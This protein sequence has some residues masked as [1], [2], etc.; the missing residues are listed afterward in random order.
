MR[1]KIAKLGTE[2]IGLISDLSDGAT[3]RHPEDGARSVTVSNSETS[4]YLRGLNNQVAQIEQLA[5]LKGKVKVLSQHIVDRASNDLGEVRNLLA[6]LRS[7]NANE[8]AN[9]LEEEHYLP[10]ANAAVTGVANRLQTLRENFSMLYGNTGV[11]LHSRDLAHAALIANVP[12]GELQDMQQI[13]DAIKGLHEANVES[14]Q[15]KFKEFVGIL[16]AHSADW[17][18]RSK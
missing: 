5:A 9:D 3:L 14:A 12:G 15:D 18:T 10:A 17:A 13:L 11:R 7:Q 1:A 2:R 4:R 8:L 6:Q 16:D